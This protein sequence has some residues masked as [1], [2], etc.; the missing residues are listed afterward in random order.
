MEVQQPAPNLNFKFSVGAH[1]ARE[2]V[3]N[4]DFEKPEE[5]SA[6]GIEYLM[7]KLLEPSIFK[8]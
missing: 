5:V 7:F 3:I 4:L 2:L 8:S 1:T 6:S